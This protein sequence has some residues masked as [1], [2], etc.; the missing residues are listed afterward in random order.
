MAVGDEIIQWI[1]AIHEQGMEKRTL[2]PQCEYPLDEMEDG[3]L[4]CMFCGWT[5]GLTLKRKML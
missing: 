2:C 4:H 3:T 1:K 5:D